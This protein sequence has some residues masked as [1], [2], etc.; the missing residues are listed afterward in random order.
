L[1]TARNSWGF[2]LF[3]DD[4]RQ[5]VGGKI[6]VMGIYQND[7]ILSPG[8]PLPAALAKFGVLI[9]YY[10]IKDVF[11]D[12]VTFRVFLPGDPSDAPSVVLP[13]QRAAMTAQVPLPYTLEEDQEHV[14]NITFPLVMAPLQIKQEGYIKVRAICGTVK[15]NLGSLMVRVARPDE[16]IPFFAPPIPAAPTSPLQ[17][18][19]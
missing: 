7:M 9:K 6:S 18:N 10:E 19:P 2:S 5:E 11:T 15:T 13:F 1:N 16:N 3:C 4:I 12:D 17:L 8:V 14:F